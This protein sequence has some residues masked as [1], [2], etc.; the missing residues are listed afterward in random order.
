[1]RDFFQYYPLLAVT[2][3]EAQANKTPMN[4]MMFIL[5]FKE[6]CL[7]YSAIHDFSV[8]LRTASIRTD[9]NCFEALMENIFPK[10]PF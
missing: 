7:Q 5:I 10:L 1:M 8:V 2:T 3:L 4:S 6:T 9:I